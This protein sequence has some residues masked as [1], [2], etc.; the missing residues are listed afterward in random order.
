MA[1][2]FLLGEYQYKAIVE[3]IAIGDVCGRFEQ[4]GTREYHTRAIG[5]DIRGPEWV[6]GDTIPQ[7][8]LSWHGAVDTAYP[9]GLAP[10]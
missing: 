5:V 2:R 4:S 6:G 10:N 9:D 3:K 7:Y 1:S 8:N